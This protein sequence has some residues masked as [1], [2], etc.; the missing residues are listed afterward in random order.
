MKIFCVGRN[1][2]DHINELGNQV[3]KNMVIFMKPNTAVHLADQPWELP[4]F[5]NEIHYE[6]E[7]VLKIAKTGKNI[8]KKLRRIISKS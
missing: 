8:Q 7:I 3:P 1:Y 6:C 2:V 4:N 5:S